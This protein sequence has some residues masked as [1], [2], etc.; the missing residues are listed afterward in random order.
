MRTLCLRGDL[1][2]LNVLN[3]WNI[4]NDLNARDADE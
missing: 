1:Y 3:D 2:I 4:L